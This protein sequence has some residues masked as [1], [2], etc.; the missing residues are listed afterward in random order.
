MP[1]IENFR[2]GSQ[3]AGSPGATSISLTWKSPS[4]P[5]R[6][7]S[8]MPALLFHGVADGLGDAGVVLEAGMRDAGSREA[9]GA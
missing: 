7:F 2:E 5:T 4:K 8:F 1:R 9:G 6:I 3:G